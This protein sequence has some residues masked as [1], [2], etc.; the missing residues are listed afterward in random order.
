MH[1]KTINI[2]RNHSKISFRFVLSIVMLA[3]I[4]TVLPSFAAD[5][6]V[7]APSVLDEIENCGQRVEN[8]PIKVPFGDSPWNIPTCDLKPYNGDINQGREYGQ[9]IYNFGKAWSLHGTNDEQADIEAQR[10]KFGV[11]FGLRGDI[12]DYGLPIYHINGNSAKKMKIKICNSNMCFPSNLDKPN[13]SYSDLNCF[14]PDAGIPWDDSF[15]PAGSTDDYFG[16]DAGDR[17]MI[18]VDDD[19]GYVYELWG[20]DRLGGE[21]LLG[22]SILYELAGKNPGS[23]LCVRSA[24]VLRDSTGERANYYTYNEGVMSSRG[25]GVQKSAM[26]VTPEEVLAGEIRHALTMGM[27]TTMGGPLCS[28]DQLATNDPNVVGKTCGFAVAPATRVEWGASTDVARGTSF[29]GEQCVGIADIAAYTQPHQTFREL[30]TLDKMTPEGM[31]F[32]ITSTDAQIESWLDSRAASDPVFEKGSRKRE[33]ARIMAVALR[34]YGWIVG[35]TSCYGAGFTMAGSANPDTK[36][37]WAQAGIEGEV[38]RD[39]LYGLFTTDNILALEAPTSTCVDGSTTKFYCKWLKSTYDSHPSLPGSGAPPTVGTLPLV[40]D[41]AIPT[42]TTPTTTTS[43]TTTPTTPLPVVTAPA[44]VEPTVPPTKP[45]LPVGPV[46]SPNKFNIF[47]LYYNGWMFQ[48]CSWRTQCRINIGWPEVTD[49]KASAGYVV[50]RTA[51]TKS[52]VISLKPGTTKLIDKAVHPNKT[53][54]Y[55]VSAKD[56]KGIVSPGVTRS[57][58][59][60]C[61]LFLCEI[62]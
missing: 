54:T 26:A 8:Y 5:P 9:R 6:P 13:C 3:L 48:P 33:T 44:T 39:L 35:D 27:Y 18:V 53:Y 40:I 24:K 32:K 15:R 25:L 2:F 60:R 17:E 20:V 41:P 11:S 55:T 16:D 50:T 31:R 62:Q 61:F 21:C 34:D 38:K 14:V 29:S 46:V 59:I 23:R 22:R 47:N 42:T 10:G 1:L 28:P 7:A 43:T 30:M 51:G 19:T 4:A 58:T 37:K 36:A 49:G 56:A 52:E 45:P 12:S 57:A